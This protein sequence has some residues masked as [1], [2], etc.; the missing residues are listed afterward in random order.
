MLSKE[1]APDP[2]GGQI[3][4]RPT[5]HA[6]PD[7]ASKSG[8]PYAINMMH[9][10]KSQSQ[11]LSLAAPAIAAL[12]VVLSLS[13]VGSAPAAQPTGPYTSVSQSDSAAG[14]LRYPDV[15]AEQ[16]VFVFA[17]DLWLVSRDGGLAQPLASPGGSERAPKFSPDGDTIAFQG[18]YEGNTDIYTVGVGGG[19]PFRVTHHPST[20]QLSE[21]T[22]DGRLIF[23]TSGLSGQGRA[24]KMFAVSAEGGL[25]EQLS[26]PYGYN[27]TMRSGGSLLAYTPNVRDNRNWKRY[28]GGMATDIWLFDLEAKTSQQVTTWEGTDSIPMWHRGTLYYLSDAGP[29]ARLNIWKFNRTNSEHSQVTR[30][31]DFDVKWPSVGP[32]DRGQGEIVFQNNTGLFL[33]DLGTEIARMIPVSVPG[34]QDTLRTKTVDVAPFLA[35]GGASPTAKR[36]AVEAR[37]DIWTLPA[38]EGRPRNLTATSGIG[39]RDPSWSPDGR[40]IAYFSDASGE[41]ELTITQS[42]GRGETRQLTSGSV[43]YRYDPT[44]SPDSTKIAFSDRSGSIYI[45]TIGAGEDGEDGTTVLVDQDTNSEWGVTVNWSHDSRWLAFVNRGQRTTSAGFERGALQSSIFL[46]DS[47]KSELHQV[48]SDMF[49][50][51]SPAFDRKGDFLYFSSDRNFSSQNGSSI[52]GSYIHE[53]TAVLLAV[54]L[55]EDVAYPWTPKSD[56]EEW[57]DES[58]DDDADEESGGDSEGDDAAEEASDDDE[59][60]DG[61]AT[62]ESD[63]ASDDAESEGEAEEE[64]S[65]EEPIEPLEIDLEGFERRAILLPVAPGAFAQLAVNDKDQLLYARRGEDGGIKLFDI[66]S[67]DREEEDVTA[68]GRFG[69]SADG[70]HILL[71]QGRGLAIA[72]AKADSTPKA[73]SMADMNATI[74]PREEWAQLYRDAWRLFRDYFY[75]G[76]MH[77]VDWDAVYAQYRPMID[78][79]VTRN[80]VD[81]VIRETIAELNVGHAYLRGGPLERGSRVSGGLLGCDYTLENGAYRIASIIEGGVWD[82]DARGPLSQTGVDVKAGDYLLAVNGIPVDAAQDPWA[83]LVGQGGKAVELTVSVNPTLDD[84]ARRVWVTALNSER[85]L[86]YRQWIEQNRATVFEKS[87]GTVGYVYVPDT[88]F[89]GRNDFFRQLYG[90]ANMDALIIDERWNGGGF[91]PTREIEALNRPISNYFG[92]RWATSMPVP[93]DSHQGPKCML[94]NRDAGSGG[95]MFPYLFK[96]AGLGKLIGTRTWGGLV[97]YSGSPTLIDGAVLSIPS[98]AFIELDGTWGVEGHGVDPDLVVMDDP[99]KMQ[100]GGD[101]QLDAAI[102]LMESELQGNAP[103]PF[104][105]PDD[106]VRAGMGLSEADRNGYLDGKD[107]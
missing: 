8:L 37:G 55:R 70:A 56:E 52:D 53:D 17:N 36:A 26:I 40:W 22:S 104:P 97:G 93:G 23:T 107:M 88:G 60:E 1:L 39:E 95:D 24:G 16:I 34:V 99:A 81:Y 35:N 64:D 73:I 100:N 41:Y 61:E 71:P 67:D 29:E 59:S 25:P 94:I 54:P 2:V 77:G 42:D 33:L 89:T 76:N 7:S 10:P 43:G 27:G 74:A 15:S 82:A 68:G 11:G 96:E 101:P 84:E 83:A 91:L 58:D 28:R 45:H 30:F 19:L 90:Q 46:F 92:R 49:S 86:R 69:M 50:D 47:T 66:H 79:C 3:I 4:S 85:T 6:G 20:E 12:G 98:F 31:G 87:G 75:A 51:S 18:N 48:T 78:A 106:P 21:W 103:I 63:D 44:W 72:D 65:E 32:G 14:M 62:D 80:D 102:A 13:A 9:R 105:R 38:D 57:G 5:P